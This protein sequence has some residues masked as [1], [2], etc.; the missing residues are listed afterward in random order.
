M[1]W[2]DTN[3]WTSPESTQRTSYDPSGFTAT[4]VARCAWARTLPP[5]LTSTGVPT[6]HAVCRRSCCVKPWIGC[7]PLAAVR[8]PLSAVCCTPPEV[9]TR[10]P[11]CEPAQL[12]STEFSAP[13]S[14]AA[15]PHPPVS[16]RAAVLGVPPLAEAPPLA[17]PCLR[18]DPGSLP[19][20]P[21][22]W[23][24]PN[25]TARP[26]SLSTIANAKGRSNRSLNA[27]GVSGSLVASAMG[28]DVL[29]AASGAGEW[30]GLEPY[31]VF[32]T[33]TRALVSHSNA[34]MPGP[35]FDTI[36]RH[37]NLASHAFQSDLGSLVCLWRRLDPWQ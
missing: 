23:S 30:V 21:G 29:A 34:G 10:W 28:D 26:S 20:R 37:R 5:K 25:T 19:G 27:T 33:C 3:L 24:S 35:Q 32:V 11:V 13:D 7:P 9:G 22:F 14:P 6:P 12:P 8:Y 31:R 16:G 4:M 15:P 36:P 2:R 1:N 17:A 18:R